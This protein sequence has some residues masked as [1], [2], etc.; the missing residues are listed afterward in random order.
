MLQNWGCGNPVSYLKMPQNIWMK[1][2]QS[3]TPGADCWASTST[4]SDGLS[5]G[6]THAAEWAHTACSRRGGMIDKCFPS[7]LGYRQRASLTAGWGN[8]NA[9]RWAGSL[10]SVQVKAGDAKPTAPAVLAHAAPVA[11]KPHEEEGTRMNCDQAGFVQKAGPGW[12]MHEGEIPESGTNK[13]IP[14]DSP[15]QGFLQR[16]PHYFTIQPLLVCNFQTSETYTQWFLEWASI[17]PTL[18]REGQTGGK[19]CSTSNSFPARFQHLAWPTQQRKLPGSS[20]NPGCG[21]EK[22]DIMHAVANKISNKILPP[23]KYW[24]KKVRE[25]GNRSNLQTSAS[26]PISSSPGE[27]TF[28]FTDSKAQVFIRSKVPQAWMQNCWA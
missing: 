23:K 4:A 19:L 21:L 8:R 20:W 16:C 5:L 13:P 1:G 9:G 28:A 24:E 26:L 12:G 14:L 10:Q 15:W 7:P 3:F 11:S 17:L 2:A 27:D 25:A 6:T 22:S 18:T